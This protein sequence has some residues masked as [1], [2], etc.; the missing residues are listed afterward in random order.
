[1]REKAWDAL[2]W[3]LR[4]LRALAVIVGFVVTTLIWTR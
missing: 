1:M 2:E 3:G 4:G